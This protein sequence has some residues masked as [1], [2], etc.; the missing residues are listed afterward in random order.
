[1]GVLETSD[2]ARYAGRE[3]PIDASRDVTL[4]HVLEGRSWG[5]LSEVDGL[6]VALGISNKHK[7]SAANAG[8]VHANH[9][10]TECCTDECVNS[11]ALCFLLVN[12]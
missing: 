10:N 4:V 6:V 3:T 11:I 1:M 5:G 7:A 9:A 8:V 2:L 12:K